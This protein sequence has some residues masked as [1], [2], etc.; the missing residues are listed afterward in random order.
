MNEYSKVLHEELQKKNAQIE[1]LNQRASEETTKRRKS[2][3]E[4]DQFRAIIE[5]LKKQLNETEMA[6]KNLK[7]EVFDSNIGSMKKNKRYE[8]EIAGLN[9]MLF[10]C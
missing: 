1:E 8:D 10:N 9:Q 6:N 4:D 3:K 7:V 5:S 2:S